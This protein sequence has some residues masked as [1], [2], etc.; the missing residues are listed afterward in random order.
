[1]RLTKQKSFRRHQPVGFT[2]VEMLVAVA[3][4][5]LMMSLFAQVFQLAGGTI[6]TQRGIAEND[7]RSRTFQNVIKA[8][9]DKRTFRMVMPW[10]VGEDG[11]LAEVNAPLREGY[12]YISENDPLNDL[13]DGLQFTM[14]VN[15]LSKNTDLSSYYGR[16]TTSS[17][18]TSTDT[19]QTPNVTYLNF[20]NQPEADDGWTIPNG[21]AEAPAAEVSYFVRGGKLYRRILLI[22]KALPVG[23]RT[24]GQPTFNDGRDAFNATPLDPSWPTPNPVAYGGINHANYN[25]TTFWYDFDHSAFIYDDPNNGSLPMYQ[26]VPIPPQAVFHSADDLSNASTLTQFPLGNPRYRFGHRT[27]NGRSREFDSSANFFGRFTHEETSN[28]NFRYPHDLSTV[29]N[30]MTA[31]INLDV[32]PTTNPLTD[33]TFPDFAFGA[34]RGEDLLLSNVHGFDVKVWDAGALGGAGAFVDIGRAVADADVYNP[35][36]VDFALSNRSNT[37]HGPINTGSPFAAPYNIN[38]VFDTWHPVPGIDIDGSAGDDPPPFRHVIYGAGATSGPYGYAVG[39]AAN[40]AVKQQSVWDTSQT[41]VAGDLVFP[42]QDVGP[43][44]PPD[45]NQRPNGLRFYYRCIRVQGSP[46]AQPEPTLQQ[47][48]AVAGG[49][50]QVPDTSNTDFYIWEAVENWKPL[51]AIQITVRFYDVT[52][53]QMRQ[54]TIVHSLVD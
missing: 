19:S 38:R 52:S 10:A 22:R 35:A 34:R 21:T 28:F 36:A 54:Q 6:T 49:R 41:Y 27:D 45:D 40:L 20:S 17:G 4:V 1:M 39:Q 48:P 2:L 43:P 47:W 50:I 18:W 13:D 15:A 5:L 51:R 30:P 53:E 29:G 37:A 32:D 25:N 12:F 9:L 7:Q 31:T 16:A 46:G 11:S 23:T 8:D 44:D 3:L 26:N 14:N 42:T 24:D 33:N